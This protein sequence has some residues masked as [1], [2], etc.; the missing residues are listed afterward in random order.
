MPLPS[1]QKQTD[2]PIDYGHGTTVAIDSLVEHLQTPDCQTDY[3]LV[4]INTLVRNRMR[5]DDQ[6]TLRQLLA[7]VLEDIH[8]FKIAV[9]QAFRL[10]HGVLLFYYSDY[11]P[12]VPIDRLRPIEGGRRQLQDLVL[13]FKP[14]IA[15]FVAG[16]HATAIEFLVGWFDHR[17]TMPFVQMAS[18]VHR[19][20]IVGVPVMISSYPSDYHLCHRFQ[21]LTVIDSFT[22][23]RWPTNQ[24]GKKVFGEEVLPF[25]LHLH[26]LLGDSKTFKPSIPPKMRK[27][28]IAKA[29]QERWIRYDDRSVCRRLI[30][31]HWYEPAKVYPLLKE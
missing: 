2:E 21:T 5:N 11:T 13:R 6:Y 19:K 9:E 24:L 28:I 15:S 23:N 12:F 29:K 22:G 18:I 8:R 10:Q 27:E 25:T 1:E 7:D 16:F 26:A 14:S 17:R 4:N 31:F 3:I 20:P 30:A